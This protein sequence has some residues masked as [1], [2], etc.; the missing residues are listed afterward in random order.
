MKPLGTLIVVALIVCLAGCQDALRFAPSEAVKQNV[1]IASESSARLAILTDTQEQVT[2]MMVDLAAATATGT[3][4]AQSYIGMPKDYGPVQ[5]TVANLASDDAALRAQG[6][7]EAGETATTATNEGSQRPTVKDV[8]GDTK[9]WVYFALDTADIWVPLF[10]G[11]GA[12]AWI[13]ALRKKVDVL[14]GALD[15]TV[16]SIEKTPNIPDAFYNRQ[17]DKLTDP[18]A[19]VIA[20]LGGTGQE[21]VTPTPVK[22]SA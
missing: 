2:P 3:K 20:D 17:T 22:P 13:M 4:A 19:K 7:I 18:E 1:A 16:T 14:F 21:V 6:K 15:T 11:V 5:V 10:G 9:S 8:V 12:A